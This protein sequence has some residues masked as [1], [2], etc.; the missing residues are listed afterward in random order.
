MWDQNTNYDKRSIRLDLFYYSNSSIIH[1]I[2]WEIYNVFKVQ[3]RSRILPKS[4]HFVNSTNFN[5][6]KEFY[7]YQQQ[8]QLISQNWV[9]WYA[10]W[11]QK[12]NYWKRERLW[13]LL[14]TFSLTDPWKA[15][16]SHLAYAICDTFFYQLK[17]WTNFWC[18]HFAS[19]SCYLSF[20]N[21][22]FNPLPK[23]K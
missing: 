14:T 15:T 23:N 11:R 21:F 6:E 20:I 17:M 9:S 4:F 19:N 13:T 2:S 8:L 22:S 12:W 16:L 5:T 18:V 10:I 7:L 3:G 1:K